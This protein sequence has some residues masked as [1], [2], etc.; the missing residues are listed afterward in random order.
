MLGFTALL[1]YHLTAIHFTSSSISGAGYE[2][3]TL[4]HLTK[5]VLTVMNAVICAV[6]MYRGTQIFRSTKDPDD[7]KPLKK[8]KRRAVKSTLLKR[9][10]ER[11]ESWP[12]SAEEKKQAAKT[13][14]RKASALSAVVYAGIACRQS[15]LVAG[16][17]AS[18]SSSVANVHAPLS[19]PTGTAGSTTSMTAHPPMPS[20]GVTPPA[21]S[22]YSPPAPPER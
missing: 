8:E 15:T 22:V 1:A 11:D 4:L 16:L 21:S 7:Y 14:V 5:F 13:I 12:R 10:R 6:V 19:R 2:Q 18:A 9:E 17:R 20:H 3:A